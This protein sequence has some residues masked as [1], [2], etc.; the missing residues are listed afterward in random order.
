MFFRKKYN[1]KNET[2]IDISLN[3]HNTTISITDNLTK[4]TNNELS[5]NYGFKDVIE[6]SYNEFKFFNNNIP[7][8]NL[9]LFLANHY[10][11]IQLNIINF[12]SRIEFSILCRMN[13]PSKIDKIY[14]SGEGAPL[15]YNEF[16]RNLKNCYL[17]TT[18]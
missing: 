5:L 2:Y 6:H 12:I 9:D 13:L 17:K 4:K 1:K 3:K 11:K 14:L 8:M 15:F 10:N 16:K 7:D 18:W